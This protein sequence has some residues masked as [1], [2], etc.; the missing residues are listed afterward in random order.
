MTTHV[1]TRTLLALL[2]V[3]TCPPFY[4][5]GK[6]EYR[7]PP[8]TVSCHS[9]C[10]HWYLFTEPFLSNGCPLWLH[11]SGFHGVLIEPL[12]SNGHIHHN[13]YLFILHL[14]V[15]HIHFLLLSWTLVFLPSC[16][17]YLFP[18]DFCVSHIEDSLTGSDRFEF[19][20]EVSLFQSQKIFIF[21]WTQQ[22]FKRYT[23]KYLR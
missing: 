17:F 20:M 4:N 3:L 2:S 10:C 15:N 14:L 11:Y 5:F 23:N 7:P 6:T 12:P 22:F 18:L 13:I 1:R 19:L 9:L 8:R 16:L 21:P